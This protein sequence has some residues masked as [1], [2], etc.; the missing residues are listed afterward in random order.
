MNYPSPQQAFYIKLINRTGAWA[1]G[2][3]LA[4]RPMTPAAL[5]AVAVK[6][7]GLEDF[8]DPD[9]RPAL[10]HLVDALES[11]ARLST[12]GRMVTHRMLEDTLAHRLRIVDYRKRHPEVARQAIRRPLIIMGLPR[13]GTTILFELLAQDP[14][15]RSPATWEIAEPVPPARG[16]TYRTDPRI[17]RV[18]RGLKIFDRDL[19]PGINAIH[20]M[21]ASLPQECLAIG[22]FQ[23]MSEQYGVNYF[24]PGYRR[25]YMTQDM[26]PTYRWHH[27]FL[28]HMQS[29]L[30][31]ERW[32]LKT[33]PHMAF[34]AALLTVYP[35]AC[36]V[37]THRDPME[38]MASISSLACAAHGGFSDH[39]DPV[40]TADLEVR[41]FA[42]MLQ[43]CLK[44]RAALA[45]ESTHFF[46]IYFQD[47]V[48][49]PIS[50]IARLYAHFGFDF[51]A[52][53]RQAMERYL[54]QRPREKHGV[55]RYTLEEF[56][57]DKARHGGL[58]E[59]YRRRFGL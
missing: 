39:V 45:N 28:Q 15:H 58:F 22:A 31:R 8:G 59:D 23:F 40:L 41:H 47:I 14:A 46:D 43:R 3:G 26:E 50:A 11:E 44:S 57:L 12:I 6:R 52:E 9:F 35:D 42:D 25:W 10:E 5:M 18:D 34:I 1:R 4:G 51:S 20:A 30:A 36:L 2:F 29:G 53:A 17:A 13:T 24:V 48:S 37:Q 49:D 33:P 16:E 54:A 38:V 55:H 32:V 21:G 56:G 19:A 27:K 7:T